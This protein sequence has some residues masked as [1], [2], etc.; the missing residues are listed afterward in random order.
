[1]PNVNHRTFLV[2]T[3]AGAL[4]LPASA[5]ADAPQT[6]SGDQIIDKGHQ[7]FGGLSGALADLVQEAGRRWGLPNAYIQ[8]QEASAAFGGGLR[9]GEGKFFYAERW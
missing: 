2:V 6:F 1:M 3:A 8:G 9:Y 4:A 7:F 5:R